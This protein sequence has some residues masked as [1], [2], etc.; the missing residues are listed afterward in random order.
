MKTGVVNLESR[1]AKAIQLPY[2]GPSLPGIRSPDANRV[3]ATVANPAD[4][5][6]GRPLHSATPLRARNAVPKVKANLRP[7]LGLNR[8]EIPLSSLKELERENGH[9]KRAVADLTLD[10]LIVEEAAEGN[11]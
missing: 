8:A 4:V 6:R 11:F 9:L 3:P 2:T 5:G 10:K 1:W 7:S